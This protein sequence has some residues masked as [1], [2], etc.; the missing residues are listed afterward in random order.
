MAEHVRDAEQAAAAAV[1]N[2]PWNR[3]SRGKN[4]LVPDP[5]AEGPHHLSAESDGEISN[6]TEW[7]DN[8]RNPT[9]FDEAKRVDMT[10]GSHWNSQLKGCPG[11]LMFMIRMRSAE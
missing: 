8:P 5:K 11:R 1:R 2:H 10:G 9:G 3:A 4:H 6:F 7:K